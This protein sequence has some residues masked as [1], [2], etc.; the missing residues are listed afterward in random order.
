MNFDEEEERSCLQEDTERFRLHPPATPQPKPLLQGVPFRTQFLTIRVPSCHPCPVHT[1]SDQ[2]CLHPDPA[3]WQ[4]FAFSHKHSPK[5]TSLSASPR[6]TQLHLPLSPTA[7]APQA[8]PRLGSSRAE[9][10]KHHWLSGWSRCPHSCLGPVGAS[11]QA[12]TWQREG[13]DK[14]LQNSRCSS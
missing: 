8:Q 1:P 6:N 12:G 4:M 14:L 2:P 7:P 10:R 13:E 11:S 5:H 3:V 9:A